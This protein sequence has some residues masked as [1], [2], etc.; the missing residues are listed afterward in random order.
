MLQGT[1]W[2]QIGKGLSFSQ[3]SPW[4]NKCFI[5]QKAHRKQHLEL[6]FAK[7]I[8]L[9]TFLCS[10]VYN[11]KT[12][13]FGFRCTVIENNLKTNQIIIAV[14]FVFSFSQDLKKYFDSC[15]GEVDPAVVKVWYSFW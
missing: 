14:L 8:Y 6:N 11:K 2:Y 15:Q 3:L 1:L 5:S 4:S 12:I 7:H 9:V 10:N 13:K